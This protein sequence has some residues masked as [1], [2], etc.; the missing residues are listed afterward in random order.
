QQKRNE[1]LIRSGEQLRKTE[2]ALR[3]ARKQL[4][5]A[6]LN[7]PVIAFAQDRELRYTWLYNTNRALAQE[8]E[9]FIGRTDEEILGEQGKPLAD[10]KRAVVETGAGTRIVFLL[11]IG[12]SQYYYDTSIEPVRDESGR[13][14]GV[15]CTALDITGQKKYEEQIQKLVEDLKIHQGELQVQTEE[16]RQAEKEASETRDQYMDLYDY[17]PVGY[18][19]MERNGVILEANLNAA[20]LLGFERSKLIHSHFTNFIVADSQEAFCFHL[21]QVLQTGIRQKCEIRMHRSDG[22]IFYATLESV[23]VHSNGTRNSIRTSLS[24]ITERKKAEKELRESEERFLK[25]F[26]S[27]PVPQAIASLP[28]ERWVEVNDSFLRMLEYTRD[29]VIGQTSA[30]LKIIDANE[31]AGILRGVLEK[32]SEQNVELTVRT[33]TGKLVTVLSFNE[34]I[35]LGGQEHCISTLLDITERKRVEQIKDEFIGMVSHELRTPLTVIIGAL[36]TAKDERASEDEREELLQEASSSAESLA[37]ILDNMIELS[38]YQAGRLKLN[39]KAV[40]ITE[41]AGMA[42]QRV[43]QKYDTHDIILDIPDEIPEIGADAGRIERVLYNLVE[44]AVKYSPPGGQVRVFSALEKRGLVIGVR[45]SGQGISSED[46]QKIFEPFARLRGSGAVGIGLGLVV[47]KRLVE[48][49][50][51]RI[52]VESTPG[53]GCAFLFTVPHGKAEQDSK[54]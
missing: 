39:K 32:G 20:S 28:E 52:W 51:G 8:G 5:A 31:R 19:T 35:T 25:A 9:S 12:G 43:R 26:H 47:C 48:A 1:E 44:N 27:S 6:F 42:V 17:A 4:D 36:A 54:R 24:D 46:Q 3:T 14:T 10:A 53:E 30:E 29:E 7:S 45:D 16:L 22:S 33:K 23:A 11:S 37:G 13:V 15:V 38:R 41:I 18:L 34:K 21:K 49:H 50:G 40:R 2:L